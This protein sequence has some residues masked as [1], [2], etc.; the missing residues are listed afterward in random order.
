MVWP[1]MA[2]RLEV[3]A[4]QQVGEA[5]VGA[6]RVER[7]VHHD[8]SHS[9]NYKPIV[10]TLCKPFECLVLVWK[11][12]INQGDVRCRNILSLRY[13]AQLC[14]HLLRVCPPTCHRIAVSKPRE[15]SCIAR[16]DC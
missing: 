7:W 16:R 15:C 9:W 13:L 6:Q 14:E 2:L 11:A 8:G 4:A 12:R 10:I 5:R 1:I 3:H